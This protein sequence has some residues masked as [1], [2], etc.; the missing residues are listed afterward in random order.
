M[1]MNVFDFKKTA[2]DVTIFRLPFIFNVAGLNWFGLARNCSKTATDHFP[3]GKC[4]KA[5]M[6][7][8]FILNVLPQMCFHISYTNYKRR[9]DAFFA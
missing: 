7:V 2:I 4:C 3:T 6:H 1:L 9:S 8:F 5:D